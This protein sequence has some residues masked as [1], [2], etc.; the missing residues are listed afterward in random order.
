[1]KPHQHQTFTEKPLKHSQW[2][3]GKNIKNTSV[4]SNHLYLAALVLQLYIQVSISCNAGVVSSISTYMQ[5][6][7]LV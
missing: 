1:M 7:V 3:K 4:V 2:I 6:A 5:L